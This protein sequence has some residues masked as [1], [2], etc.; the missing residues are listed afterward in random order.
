MMEFPIYLYFL[1]L[2][3]IWI[4]TTVEP[5]ITSLIRSN[6]SLVMRKTRYAGGSFAYNLYEKWNNWFHLKKSADI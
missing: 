3:F 6:D 1:Y 4:D 2:F 5:L